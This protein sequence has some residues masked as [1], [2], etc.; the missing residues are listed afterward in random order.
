MLRSLGIYSGLFTIVAVM[1]LLDTTEVLDDPEIY[2]W[3]GIIIALSLL[4]VVYKTFMDKRV[5]R[6]QEANREKQDNEDA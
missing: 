6:I 3:C 5:Q 1:F 2:V 4:A